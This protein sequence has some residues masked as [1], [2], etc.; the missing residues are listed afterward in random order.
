MSILQDVNYNRTKPIFVMKNVI[1]K[2]SK[3]KIY[4]ILECQ[5]NLFKPSSPIFFVDILHDTLPLRIMFVG[6]S[7]PLSLQEKL[8]M[9]HWFYIHYFQ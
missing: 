3:K 7:V 9:G 8:Q 4:M 5:R 6:Q 2:S 1:F